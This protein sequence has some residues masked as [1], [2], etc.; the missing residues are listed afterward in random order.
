MILFSSLSIIASRVMDDW[1]EYPSKS[2]RDTPRG[3]RRESS[4]HRKVEKLLNKLVKYMLTLQSMHGNNNINEP[5]YIAHII[6]MRSLCDVSIFL[7]HYNVVV[8]KVLW[9]IMQ[10]IKQEQRGF[11]DEHSQ[12]TYFFYLSLIYNL[13]ALRKQKR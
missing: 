3:R 12:Q 9:C 10:P 11:F 13:L 5:S 2:T 4:L 1:K 8:N 6:V 7:Q